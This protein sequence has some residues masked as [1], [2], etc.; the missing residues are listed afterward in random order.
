MTTQRTVVRILAGVAGRS[1]TLMVGMAIGAMDALTARRDQIIQQP[2][3]ALQPVVAGVSGGAIAA[4]V[5]A[6]GMTRDQARQIAIEHPE[7]NVLGERSFRAMLTRRT[8]YPQPRIRELAHAIVGD[9]T[10][11]D[12]ALDPKTS[13][14]QPHQTE[15]SLLI[16][17]Y[18]AEHGTLLLPRDLPKLGLSDLPVADALVAA[19]RIPGALPAAAGLEDIFDG[20]CK[21]RVPHDIFAPHPALILDLYGPEPHDSRGGLIFPLLHPSLPAIAHR[22]RPFRDETLRE[23]TIFA[24][25]PYG[26]ALKAPTRAPA[27]LFDTGYDITTTWI[28][29]RTDHELLNILDSHV[30]GLPTEAAAADRIQ[31][32]A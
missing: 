15:S 13:G 25:Q 2:A 7:Q 16:P 1:L 9:R 28:D 20:G 12:F 31:P 29:S 32:I 6:L 10:F 26:A 30:L 19:T 3:P 11:A 22:P 8:L 14:Q 24:H 4:A 23:S 21:Y 18:S 17:V 27:E 5:I